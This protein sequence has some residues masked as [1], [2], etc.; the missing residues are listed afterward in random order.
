MGGQS[1]ERA[2][3]YPMACPGFPTDSQWGHRQTAVPVRDSPGASW[4]HLTGKV[5][6]VTMRVTELIH[7]A[8]FRTAF[9]CLS[10]VYFPAVWI[11]AFNIGRIT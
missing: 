8:L 4:G 9:S 1:R 2:L 3:A 11:I 7:R 5:R 10:P 6:G